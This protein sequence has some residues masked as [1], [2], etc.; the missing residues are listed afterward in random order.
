[1]YRFG[2]FEASRHPWDDVWR[3]HIG[4]HDLG[5]GREVTSVV[6][7]LVMTNEGL[8]IFDRHCGSWP[9]AVMVLDVRMNQSV[10]RR[11]PPDSI[12]VARDARPANAPHQALGHKRAKRARWPSRLH[13]VVGLPLYK[14]TGQIPAPAFTLERLDRLSEFMG[15]M[16]FPLKDILTALALSERVMG[17]ESLA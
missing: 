12:S 16:N 9:Y 11:T 5:Q 15:A 13:A 17:P 8:V 1:V 2:T 6:G 7:F 10:A 14:G 3:E 4:G